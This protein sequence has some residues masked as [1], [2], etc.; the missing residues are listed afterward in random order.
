MRRPI[1][2]WILFACGTVSVLASLLS[3]IATLGY[4]KPVKHALGLP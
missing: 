1:K 3:I 4:L 2:K